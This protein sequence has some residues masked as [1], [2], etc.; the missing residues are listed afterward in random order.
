MPITTP[1]KTTC[2]GDLLTTLPHI[3]NTLPKR[4]F[5][6]APTDT[7]TTILTVLCVT[8]PD[9]TTTI[10]AAHITM[11]LGWGAGQGQGGNGVGME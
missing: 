2:R 3:G 9:T 1:T 7:T 11:G 10:T 6:V 8:P 5:T 4:A